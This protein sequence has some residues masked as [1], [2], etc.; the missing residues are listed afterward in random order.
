VEYY[1]G[2]MRASWLLIVSSALLPVAL[3]PGCENDVGKDPDAG[4]IGA[5]GEGEGEGGEGEGECDDTPV[6]GMKVVV[7]DALTQFPICD[8]EV[9]I[10]DGAFSETLTPTGSGADCD[11]SSTP[12]RIGVFDIVV[13][14][15]DYQQGGVTDVEVFDNGCGHAVLRRVEVRLD[16][17]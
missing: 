2:T 9:D 3:S 8:A 14:H 4:V 1:G 10:N 12:D 5:E 17:P 15:P 7:K 11:Y 13:T 6:I 16:P